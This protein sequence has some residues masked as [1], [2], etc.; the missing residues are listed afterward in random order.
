MV[1]GVNVVVVRTE[2]ELMALIEQGFKPYYHKGVGR[3]YLRR[4]RERHIIDRSLEAKAQ[5]IAERLK[6]LLRRVPEHKVAEAIRMRREG[7]PVSAVIEKTGI[8][9]STLYKKFEEYDE[10]K[11]R[12]ETLEEPVQAEPPESMVTQKTPVAAQE[13]EERAKAPDVIGQIARAIQEFFKAAQESFNEHAKQAQRILSKPENVKAIA[14]I[15]VSSAE[16]GFLLWGL[17]EVPKLREKGEDVTPIVKKMKEIV[18][19]Y[20]SLNKGYTRR[21]FNTQPQ[22]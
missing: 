22:G 18:D 7:A 20:S 16:F 17:L 21:N 8:P 3:W 15:I 2:E 14:D 19:K 12:L 11:L 5:A 9:R 4:G 13:V 6:P 10:G 1:R